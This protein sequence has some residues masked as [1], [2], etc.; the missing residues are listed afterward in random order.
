MNDVLLIAENKIK[1]NSIHLY[2]FYLPKEFIEEAGKREISIV[3]VYNPPVRRN[4]IDYLG[5]SMEF[6]L[7]KDSNVEEI[8]YG[9][10]SILKTGIHPELED[11]VPEELKLKEIDLH[12]GVRTRKKGLHQKGIKIYHRR[13][14]ID[15][16]KPL[17][18]TVISQDRWVNTP[19]YLQDYAVVVKIKH[20]N[21]IDIYNQIKQK[22]EIEERIRIRP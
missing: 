14:S 2:Y 4:R 10:R 18:L 12:P 21:R 5:I 20:T 13:P 6:H 16:E 1:P 11:I 17:I 9:Y 7:F 8:I 19:D 22:V 3:L 15:Y